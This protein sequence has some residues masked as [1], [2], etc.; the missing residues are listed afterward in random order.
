LVSSFNTA[1][2]AGRQ[3]ME[4]RAYDNA[5]D[6]TREPLSIA[7]TV[8][9][10]RSEKYGTVPP[11]LPANRTRETI[12]FVANRLSEAVEQSEAVLIRAE[13]EI[14]QRGSDLV[15]LASPNYVVLTAILFALR[16]YI[17]LRRRIS[18]QKSPAIST[19][20]DMPITT[21]LLGSGH[22]PL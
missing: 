4:E 6:E 9:Q 17:R 21:A 8:A 15:V 14:Y 19:G 20:R 7:G 11:R 18:K 16:R 12:I 22:P 3:V 1:K 2:R 13:A 10:L 5:N